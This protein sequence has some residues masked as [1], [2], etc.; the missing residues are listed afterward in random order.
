MVGKF[1]KLPGDRFLTGLPAHELV[2]GSYAYEKNDSSTAFYE[3]PTLAQAI[4]RNFREVNRTSLKR[5]DS[6]VF[7]SVEQGARNLSAAT[8]GLQALLAST[9][10]ANS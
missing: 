3:Q 9:G 7:E 2:N 8:G 5:L 4:L 6:S 10:N 1:Y